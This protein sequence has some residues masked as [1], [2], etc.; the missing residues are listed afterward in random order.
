MARS[1]GTVQQ[2][3]VARRLVN[4]HTMLGDG[5]SAVAV[6]LRGLQR[7]GIDW[8]AHPSQT[9]AR[10]ECERFWALL[11]DR[12][13]EDIL[14]LPLMRDPETLATLDLLTKL[15]LPAEYIDEN[16]VAL[17]ICRVANLSLDRGNNQAA[18]VNYAAMGMLAS[19]R[20]GRSRSRAERPSESTD[21]ASARFVGPQHL[22]RSAETDQCR[23]PRRM[24]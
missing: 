24:R 15:S 13:I 2:C 16:L 1:V 5:E 7:S 14:D 19:A 10:L 3:A 12:T 8:S 9:E 22:L 20:F 17:S 18:P 6:A 4:L 21:L 23:C 11:G